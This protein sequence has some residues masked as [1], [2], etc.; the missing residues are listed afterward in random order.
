MCQGP[1]QNI[2]KGLDFMASEKMAYSVDEVA[3]LLGISRPTAYQLVKREDFPS[4]RLSQR[5]IVVPADA[6]R[7]WLNRSETGEG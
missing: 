4:V 2:L 6:L 1:R 7:E 3:E 5:R